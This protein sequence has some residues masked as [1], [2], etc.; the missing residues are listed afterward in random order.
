MGIFTFKLKDLSKL[1]RIINYDGWLTC[2]SSIHYHTIGFVHIS[3]VVTKLAETIGHHGW[4]S[5]KHWPFWAWKFRERQHLGAIKTSTEGKGGTCSPCGH[6]LH[7][8][9]T[10]EWKSNRLEPKM[11]WRLPGYPL[12]LEHLL[13]NP[14]FRRCSQVQQFVG[15]G[16]W[17]QS[18][19]QALYAMSTTSLVGICC[20][21][22]LRKHRKPVSNL[23]TQHQSMLTINSQTFNP[24]YI[25]IFITSTPYPPTPSHHVTTPSHYHHPPV[26]HITEFS[27]TFFHRQLQI[28][29]CFRPK[30]EDVERVGMTPTRK[31]T[32][33]NF[34]F[35]GATL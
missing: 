4:H 14:L 7:W 33:S 24:M 26:D 10:S 22:S 2:N 17:Q 11:K 23:I 21:Y 30:G 13:V 8:V 20:C 25:Y 35:W 28:R 29:A 3:V 27:Y 32:S 31:P 9:A 12:R 1:T 16:L 18:C 34:H 6:C 19:F 15:L 5:S